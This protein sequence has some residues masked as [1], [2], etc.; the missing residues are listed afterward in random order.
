MTISVVQSLSPVA[1][2]NVPSL[3]SGAFGSPIT[4]GN[5]I[6]VF[7]G[8]YN[9]TPTVSDTSGNTYVQDDTISGNADSLRK[10]FV[11][12][13]S[14]CTGG[15]N[16]KITV[17]PASGS[18]YIAFTACEVSELT[19]SSPEDVSS[20]N[21][22]DMGTAIT[23][24]A[25]TTTN[26]NNIIFAFSAVINTTLRTYTATPT[27]FTLIGKQ[28]GTTTIDI[29]ARYQIV[30][31]IQSGINPS[32][33]LNGGDNW[34]AIGSS[35]KAAAAAGGGPFPWYFD[36]QSGGLCSMGIGL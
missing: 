15:S 7:I 2:N 12:R 8:W 16:F 25:F 22:S 21:S 14:N 17:T 18:S 26:A 34:L 10:A 35:Y 29:D 24:G 11:F 28:D 32:W 13:C 20:T 5:T 9:S 1:G 33:T 36:E 6:F 19:N 23:T 27:G 3:Q 4:S 30:S 31:L